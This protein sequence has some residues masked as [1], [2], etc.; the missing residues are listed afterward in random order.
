MLSL[1]VIWPILTAFFDLAHVTQAAR[2]GAY[3]KVVKIGALWPLS[4][5]QILFYTR[6]TDRKDN[7]LSVR[8]IEVYLSHFDLSRA[9]Y[10]NLGK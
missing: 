4:L 2:R 1:A 3:K 10:P 8:L 7:S 9:I 6:A 5:L